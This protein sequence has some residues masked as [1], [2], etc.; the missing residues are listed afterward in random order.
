LLNKKTH[1]WI[2]KYRKIQIS[3]PANN[4]SKW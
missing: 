2:E 3:A 1:Y 4:S